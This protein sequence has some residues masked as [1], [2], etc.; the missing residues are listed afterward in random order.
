M[1]VDKCLEDCDG[2]HYRLFWRKEQGGAIVQRTIRVCQKFVGNTVRCKEAFDRL[3]DTALD[4]GR[5]IGRL[6]VRCQEAW[7][8]KI[9]AKIFHTLEGPQARWNRA[10]GWNRRQIA[11][12]R[13]QQISIEGT[14]KNPLCVLCEFLCVLCGKILTAKNTKVYA[15]CAKKRICLKT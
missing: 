2:R 4:Y 5:S 12:G 9:P 15:K 6:P 8:G 10:T 14:S 3:F 11:D 7:G 1:E 13:Q